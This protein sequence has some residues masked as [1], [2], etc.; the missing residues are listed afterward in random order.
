MS[1]PSFFTQAGNFASAVAGGVDQRTGQFTARIT[2]GRPLGRQPQ[3][4]PRSAPGAELLAGPL[5]FRGALVR[6]TMTNRIPDYS[7]VE[8]GVRNADG[9]SWKTAVAEIS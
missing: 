8:V 7:G 9:D 3:P 5:A 1:S 4:G 2:L 6:I